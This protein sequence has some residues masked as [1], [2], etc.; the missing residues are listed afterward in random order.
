MRTRIL[1]LDG[2]QKSL[3]ITAIN[4][5]GVSIFSWKRLCRQQ[6]T[7]KTKA[8]AEKGCH[9]LDGKGCHSRV[10]IVSSVKEAAAGQR[11]RSETSPATVTIM[12]VQGTSGAK[13]DHDLPGV[14]VGSTRRISAPSSP[15]RHTPL[16]PTASDSVEVR[17]GR[18]DGRVTVFISSE[19]P[20]ERFGSLLFIYS[21][22]VTQS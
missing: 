19:S 17:T 6:Q 18:E 7:C 13:V 10:S 11:C 21:E 9:A 16:S 2:L 12:K 1:R 22:S 8:P 5:P 14:H 20:S 3:T 15:V 4:H